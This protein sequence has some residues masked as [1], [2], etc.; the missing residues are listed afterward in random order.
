MLLSDSNDAPPFQ[1]YVVTIL[2]VFQERNF[3]LRSASSRFCGL[4]V[5]AKKLCSNSSKCA[6]GNGND[7]TT[8]LR[9]CINL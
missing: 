9:L 3:Q 5:A 4:L 8:F 7:N 6:I 1:T 2:S